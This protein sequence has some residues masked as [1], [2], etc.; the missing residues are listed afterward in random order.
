MDSTVLHLFEEKN[1]KNLL[2][3]LLL[4]IANNSH[5]LQLTVNNKIS[6]S[7]KKLIKK[8]NDVFM[9][10]AVEYNL[11][12]L[13]ELIE[14]EEEKIRELILNLLDKRKEEMDEKVK[15]K[16]EVTPEDIVIII[17]ESIKNF[18]QTFDVDMNNAIYINMFNRIIEKYKL[19]KEEAKEK[20]NFCLSRYD[21]ILSDSILDS[22]NDRNS[23]LKNI[24]KS[25][26]EDYIDINNK[27]AN[28]LSENQKENNN[29]KTKEKKAV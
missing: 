19:T 3:K 22:I 4:D 29:Q 15:I 8:I 13:T 17:D 16:D 28:Y 21:H 1:K 6:L 24:T 12:D 9:E 7:T 27:T 20:I 26:Y 25:T 5:S 2:D 18:R 11:K 23:T 10:Y 14:Q